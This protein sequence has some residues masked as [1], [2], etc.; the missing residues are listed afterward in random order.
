M[1]IDE[2]PDTMNRQ[3][4]FKHYGVNQGFSRHGNQSKC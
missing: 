3:N 4:L 2:V 1:A